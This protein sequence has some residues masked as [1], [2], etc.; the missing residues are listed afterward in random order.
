MKDLTL[1]SEKWMRIFGEMRPKED[2]KQIFKCL[3]LTKL[4][5]LQ[6]CQYKLPVVDYYKKLFNKGYR[7]AALELSRFF[8]LP[9]TLY[10][11]LKH[12]LE[13]DLMRFIIIVSTRFLVCVTF[14]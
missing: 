2:R 7:G 13:R 4:S 1:N 5:S 11:L 10:P 3:W 9:C 8:D 6:C 12:K 14:E